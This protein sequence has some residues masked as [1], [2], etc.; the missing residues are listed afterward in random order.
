MASSGVHPTYAMLILV[1]WDSL[2]AT[3]SR[4]GI[5]IIL[6]RSRSYFAIHR[7]CPCLDLRSKKERETKME[8]EKKKME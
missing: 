7:C 1:K 2:L 3:S 5:R 4:Y 8:K 6:S